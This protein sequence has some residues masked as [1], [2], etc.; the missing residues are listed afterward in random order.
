MSHRSKMKV[1][2]LLLFS[3]LMISSCTLGGSSE[4]PEPEATAIPTD[5]VQTQPTALPATEAPDQATPMP[6]EGE[7][8]APPATESASLPDQ[9][10][11]PTGSSALHATDPD[12]VNLA[13]GDP[14][15]VEF[16]AFW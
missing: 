11:V 10:A 5:P 2:S 4:P 12:S 9:G 15:L 16:F 6:E 8:P 13:D 14:T 3:V 7:T 1:T